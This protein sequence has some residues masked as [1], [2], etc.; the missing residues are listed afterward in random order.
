MAFLPCSNLRMSNRCSRGAPAKIT[1]GSRRNT[2][3]IGRKIRR[4]CCLLPRIDRSMQ[5]N[6]LLPQVELTM[7]SAVI[8]RWLVRVGD[9]VQAAQPL[10]E[11]ETQ[12]AVS[13]VP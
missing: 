1:N 8:T 4:S 11:V 7:E 6:V 3:N 13:E 10:V 2:S 5:T 9:R 12:K